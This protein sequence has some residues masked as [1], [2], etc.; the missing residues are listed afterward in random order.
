V[1]LRKDQ[2][3]QRA[4]CAEHGVPYVLT[5]EEAIVYLIANRP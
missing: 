1:K 4:F 3:K 2:E 5:G